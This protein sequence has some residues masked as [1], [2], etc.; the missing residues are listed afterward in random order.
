MNRKNRRASEK[1]KRLKQKKEVNS[2]NGENYKIDTVDNDKINQI[3][4][5][6][7]N[8]TEDIKKIFNYTKAL[9]SKLNLLIET[10]IRKEELSYQD[11][12][13]TQSLYSL[14]EARKEQRIKELLSYDLSIDELF[15]EIRENPDTP[16][17]DR[18]GINLVKDLN[19]NP[20]ELAQ[21]IR[22]RN[23]GAASEDILKYA[24]QFGLS[25]SHFGLDIQ[26][27]LKQS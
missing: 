10:F 19:V 13:D 15:S 4:S 11:L 6:L 14:K 23:K 9:E 18:L 24:K 7:N 2:T 20:Y 27:D 5:H 22:D 1:K 26:E 12:R 21:Y 16:G 3:V 17:Y 8:S 25:E